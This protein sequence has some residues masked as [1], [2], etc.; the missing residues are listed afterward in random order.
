MNSINTKGSTLLI[1][2]LALLSGLFGSCSKD[3][4]NYNYSEISELA[5]SN[6]EQQ[7]AV[8]TGVD[9]LILSPIVGGDLAGSSEADLE[10]RWTL[11]MQGTSRA[12]DTIGTS[13]QLKFPVGVEK[14]QYL[15]EFR[16]RDR[17]TGI[18]FSKR[19]NLAV[20]TPFTRGILI[21]G[22][23]QTGE[24]EAQMLSMIADTILMDGLIRNSGLGQTLTKPGEIMYGGGFVDSHKLVWIFTESGTYF[25]DR[26]RMSSASTNTISSFL[27]P[28]DPIDVQQEQPIAMAPQII[29]SD[30]TISDE[31]SRAIVTRTGNIYTTSTLLGQGEFYNPINRLASDFERL[32]P[33][34]PFLMYPLGSM[35]SMMW[36]NQ[37]EDRFMALA[38]FMFIDHSSY[39]VEA[40]GEVFSWNL[41]AQG[42]E[43][44]YAENTFNRDGGFVNGNTFAVV[45]EGSKQR[46]IYKF[47][48]RGS[49][50]VKL[51]SY[52]VKEIAFNFHQAEQYAFSSNRTVVFYTVNQR[53]FA[54]DY[55]PGNERLYPLDPLPGQDITMIKFDTQQNPAE[56]SLYIAGYKAGQGTLKR[57][58]LDNNPNHVALQ[59]VP[60]AAWDG[61]LKIKNINWKAERY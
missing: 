56:N 39:P 15:L 30:G 23:T 19:A 57:F 3:L 49:N 59:A 46:Y 28:T 6:L 41:G 34:A 7:Y 47:H 33:A 48:A 8:L 11:R 29:K 54:Y 14:G 52:G 16:V 58:N 13:A 37:E 5:I 10:Y 17:S 25:F 22:E 20:S 18:V 38:G 24:V 35:S 31:F 40:A 2:G 50:P 44:I 12:A 45:G 4:G 61:L 1:I 27:M 43:L 36:Y 32:L 51:A 21:L 60:S 26:E 9:T 55:N 42:Q 53:L